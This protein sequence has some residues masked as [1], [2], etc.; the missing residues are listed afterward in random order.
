MRTVIMCIVPV[1]LSACAS[2]R[3]DWGGVANPMPL[4]SE[5]VDCASADLAMTE[6]GELVFPA[7]LLRR[8]YYT[9]NRE[10]FRV[11]LPF[12]YDVTPNGEAIN[13]VF[14]GDEAM[15]RDSA[16]RD[17]ILFAA[18]SIL[19]SKFAWPDGAGAQYASGCE[20]NINL[21]SRLVLEP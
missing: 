3:V 10:G 18:N 17:A 12:T 1:L 20:A 5:V 13:V 14:A 2:D 8:A 15:T 11:E 21:G 16:M 7:S 19:D 6:Q 9:Q 4:P